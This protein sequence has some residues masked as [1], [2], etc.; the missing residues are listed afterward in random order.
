MIRFIAA[1]RRCTSKGIADLGAASVKCEVAYY[2]DDY[3]NNYD[4]V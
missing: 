4:H 1:L 2:E 3:G